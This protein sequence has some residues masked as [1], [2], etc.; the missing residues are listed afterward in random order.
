MPRKTVPRPVPAV[1]VEVPGHGRAKSVI[2][3]PQKAARSPPAA[4][5]VGKHGPHGTASQ[6]LEGDL[7]AISKV[8]LSKKDVDVLRGMVEQVGPEY[9]VNVDFKMINVGRKMQKV[10][11]VVKDDLI[12]LGINGVDMMFLVDEIIA[13]LKTE[14]EK[15]FYVNELIR[16]K[17][18]LSYNAKKSA[19][20][21]KLASAA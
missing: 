17:K 21:K 14:I 8:K 12:K 5:P 6:V 13:N 15:R 7:L 11:D 16:Y 3:S 19:D 20:A 10:K 9:L 2:N 4:S 18:R 1:L